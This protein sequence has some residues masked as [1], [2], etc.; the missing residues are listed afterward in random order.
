[1]MHNLQIFA[2]Y[3]LLEI[4]HLKKKY[5]LIY[6]LSVRFRSVISEG[7]GTIYQPLRSDRIWYKVNFFT[8]SLTGLNSEFSFS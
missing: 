4:L 5:W 6:W 8:R 3:F 1:M 7:Q 2:D